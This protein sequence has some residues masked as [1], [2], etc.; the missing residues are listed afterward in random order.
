VTKSHS[1]GSGDGGG[2]TRP[3]RAIGAWR[4][5]TETKNHRSLNFRMAFTSNTGSGGVAKLVESNQKL[6]RL[7]MRFLG[8]S[9][10]PAVMA[11][12]D[13]R[14]AKRIVP[15][16]SGMT[17]TVHSGSCVR[18]SSTGRYT[19][20]TFIIPIRENQKQNFAKRSGL[21]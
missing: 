14:H 13:K 5:F 7:P 16:W 11:Q 3:F 1:G 20:L 9:S 8:P 21:R 12:P 6:V 2:A 18:R 10:L 19:T 17:C 15:C 4:N